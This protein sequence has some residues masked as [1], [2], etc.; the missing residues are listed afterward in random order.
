[1]TTR[2]IFIKALFIA[3]IILFSQSVFAIMIGLST[4]QLT[5]ASQTII[6]GQ[7]VDVKSQWND[8]G[9]EIVTRADVAVKEIIRGG[10]NNEK[11]LIVEYEGGEIGDIGL[12][13]SDSPTLIKGENVVLFLEL[14]KKIKTGLLCKIVGRAQGKYSIGKDGIARKAG[15]NVIKGKDAIENDIPINELVSRIRAVK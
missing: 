5:K 2:F 4:E 10:F 11:H 15:F 3:A 8:T 7:V 13:V 14:F 1:M 6:T 12:R 9:D